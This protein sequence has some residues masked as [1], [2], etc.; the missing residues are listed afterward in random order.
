MRLCILAMKLM[1]SKRML[2]AYGLVGIFCV[3][4]ERN[5]DV[6][7]CLNYS[8]H[9]HINEIKPFS[10]WYISEDQTPCWSFLD[11]VSQQSRLFLTGGVNMGLCWVR[12][13]EG[14]GSKSLPRISALSFS[15]GP[16]IVCNA[17]PEESQAT[18]LA[19]VRNEGQRVV[20][21]SWE[22]K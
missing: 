6:F 12:Y 4:R 22:S 16:S 18:W 15:T 10:S 5:T 13:I 9:P 14:E 7:W 21:T 20:T 19:V 11:L 1:V 2:F 3:W 8:F 17:S